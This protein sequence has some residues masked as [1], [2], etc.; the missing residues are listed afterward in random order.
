MKKRLFIILIK[1]NI[2]NLNR[3]GTLIS[4]LNDIS[5][6]YFRPPKELFI[7]STITFKTHWLRLRA[8]KFWS[9]FKKKWRIYLN[10]LKNISVCDYIVF[11]KNRN[12]LILHKNCLLFSKKVS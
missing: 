8:M 2:N 11:G 6:T 12:W 1:K 7:R 9:I 3:K 5:P 4:N 10:I